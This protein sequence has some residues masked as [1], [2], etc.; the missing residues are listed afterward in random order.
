VNTF[1]VAATASPGRAAPLGA[2]R[3]DPLRLLPLPGYAAL[4]F[5]SLIVLSVS[6]VNGSLIPAKSFFVQHAIILHVF[7]FSRFLALY[8]NEW[9]P[10]KLTL[11]EF[12]RRSGISKP[13]ISK[14][15]KNGRI[16]AER[17]ENG[18]YRID[19]VELDRLG[20]IRSHGNREVN[21]LHEHLETP[22]E[23]VTETV[24][25]REVAL[26]REMLQDKDRQ[27]VEMRQEK[28]DWKRQAQTL[29]LTAGEKKEELKKKWWRFGR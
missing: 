13:Y 18:Q 24:L 26:L 27:L 23:T 21:V 28:E 19:P 11:G 4:G 5:T 10:M 20:T 9:K 25:Q 8:I 17:L 2:A 7:A 3:R 29:L 22:Q 1:D 16:S 15:I 6:F 12:S 14:L